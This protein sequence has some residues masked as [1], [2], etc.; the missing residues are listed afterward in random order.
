MKD[1]SA[2]YSHKANALAMDEFLS[3]VAGSTATVGGTVILTMNCP[4]KSSST[5]SPE[6]MFPILF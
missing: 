2:I 5:I 6:V 4:S 3:E 1:F